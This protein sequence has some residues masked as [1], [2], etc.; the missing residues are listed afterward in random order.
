MAGL[1]GSSTCPVIALLLRHQYVEPDSGG[2]P[3]SIALR[4]SLSAGAASEDSEQS[5]SASGPRSAASLLLFLRPPGI[6]KHTDEYGSI[7]NFESST[8]SD[9]GSEFR[10]ACCM[11]ARSI[12]APWLGRLA[13]SGRP[14]LAFRMSTKSSTSVI[15]SFSIKAGA[16][17]SA[18]SRLVAKGQSHDPFFLS[19]RH[20]LCSLLFASTLPFPFLVIKPSLPL[21]FLQ[22]T[23]SSCKTQ[24]N[25]NA[26]C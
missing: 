14:Q 24:A 23:T 22:L 19:Q 20:K 17:Q 18:T 12:S 13:K 8:R 10:I 5:I 6:S 11:Q 21:L 26:K 25:F 2:I 16:V 9:Q 1:R 3:K 7:F 4:A 15:F